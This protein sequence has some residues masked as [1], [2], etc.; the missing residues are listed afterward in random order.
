[1]EE[2]PPG[3]TL[4]S[5]PLGYGDL[6]LNAE[7]MFSNHKGVHKKRIEKRQ[8]KLTEKLDAL[9]HFLEDGEQILLIT[10]ACSPV[11]LWEQLTIGWMFLYL[12][13]PENRALHG[14]GCTF[15]PAARLT[16]NRKSTRVQ[17]A[18]SS[19]RTR[20]RRCDYLFAIRAAAIST[21]ATPCWELATPSPKYSCWC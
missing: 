20:R 1:M 13:S 11:S 6:S 3:L 10:T 7:I 8:T 12:K 15:A 5:A 14:A 19:S 18:A 21:P 17:T 16:S 4:K 9:P 2:Q